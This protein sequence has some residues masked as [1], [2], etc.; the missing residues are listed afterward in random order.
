MIRLLFTS[1]AR[2]IVDAKRYRHGGIYVGSHRLRRRR[3]DF[4]DM[5][6]RDGSRSAQ[7]FRPMPLYRRLVL[8]CRGIAAD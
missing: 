6:Y 1:P 2:G 3:G 7:P 8:V 5:I 4:L